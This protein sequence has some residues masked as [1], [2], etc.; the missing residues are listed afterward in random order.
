M[1]LMSSYYLGSNLI[2]TKAIIPIND[3]IKCTAESLIID[4]TDS[5]AII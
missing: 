1:K 5:N 3:W 2:R 4:Y